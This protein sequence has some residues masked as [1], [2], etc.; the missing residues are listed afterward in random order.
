MKLE[1]QSIHF[2]ATQALLDFIKKKADKLETFHDGIV[3]GE[4]FLKIEKNDNPKDNKSVEVK[5]NIP[6][7]TLFAKEI[8]S[9]FEAAADE[10]FEALRRQLVKHKEK[11]SAK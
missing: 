10:A 3:G 5:L 2:D 11:Q 4:V 9:S 7:S 1:I 8:G 6:G